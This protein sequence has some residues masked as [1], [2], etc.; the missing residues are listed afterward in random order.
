MTESKEGTVR[1]LFV[2]DERDFLD[3]VAPGLERRG[4]EV[5]RAEN[6]IRALQLLEGGA[7]DVVVLDVKMPGLDGVTVFRRMQELAP[8]LPVV[9][10]TG[11]GSLRQAFETSRQGV[12][13]YLLKPCDMETLA[14]V[15]HRAAQKGVVARE[16]EPAHAEADGRIEVLMVDDDV[17]FLG[18]LTPALA[19][20]GMNVTVA[21]AGEEALAL[22]RARR[23]H[24]ALVDVLMPGMDGITLMQRL[25]VEDPLLEVLILTG[26]P[27]VAD[28][29]TALEE[30]RV[31]RTTERVLAE[32]PG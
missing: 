27:T 19:R 5:T 12:F 15:A 21:H 26:N 28:A 10:L 13:D 1:L 16:E 4:F 6:G 30:E 22:S 2:D 32:R 7:F 23:F 25:K 11:H 3:A 9:L 18:A 31:R 29:R 17:D 8:G 20:R 24:V 14:E